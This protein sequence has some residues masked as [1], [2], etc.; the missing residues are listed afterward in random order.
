MEKGT[1]IKKMS[2]AFAVILIL[3]ILLI[4]YAS[5]GVIGDVELITLFKSGSA[6]IPGNEKPEEFT[7]MTFN[8]GYF[9][10]MKNNTSESIGKDFFEK[11]IG[12][13]IGF[14][15]ENPIDIICFQEIDFNSDRTYRVNQAK[16]VAKYIQYPFLSSAVN[17]NKRYVPYPY[18]P[19][20]SHFKQMLSGQAVLSMFPII[21]NKRVVLKKPQRNFLYNSFYLDRLIHIVKLNINNREIMVFNIHLEAFEQETREKQ[22]ISVLN[23]YNKYK[24]QYPVIISGDFNCVPPNAIK[25]KGFSDEPETDY[26]NDRTIEYFLKESSLKGVMTDNYKNYRNICTFSSSVPDRKLDYIFY[27]RKN[28]KLVGGK[29]ERLHISDHFPLI[30]RFRM[31]DNDRNR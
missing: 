19:V 20:S 13:F 2:I 3:I 25:K 29:V 14:V 30:A 15:K 21:E 12:K 5:S 6:Y 7:I 17:W 11:N 9:S 26:S 16:T 28:L 23:F 10:G 18:W 4:L 27:S 24:N 22:A 31:V 1:A 8:C